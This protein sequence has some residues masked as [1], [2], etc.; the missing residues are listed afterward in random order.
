[1]PQPQDL[2]WIVYVIYA[3]T[4]AIVAYAV[5]YIM[6]ERMAKRMTDKELDQIEGTLYLQDDD[7]QMLCYCDLYK[8]PSQFEDGQRVIFIVEKVD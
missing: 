7:G 3:V 8:D 1:M 6:R 4:V 2:Q 5:V